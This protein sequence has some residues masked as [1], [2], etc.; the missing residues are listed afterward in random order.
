[1]R[2][3][4]FFS[5]SRRFS[6]RPLHVKSPLLDIYDSTSNL[7]LYTVHLIGRLQGF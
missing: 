3:P 6:L 4:G 1:M 5:P 2:G 7:S